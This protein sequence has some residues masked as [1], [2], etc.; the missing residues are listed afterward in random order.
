MRSNSYQVDRTKIL[1]VTYILAVR[2]HNSWPQSRE[3]NML[4]GNI[5]VK[6]TE[7]P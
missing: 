5:S 4:S 1:K 6:L 7:V 2:A 3:L